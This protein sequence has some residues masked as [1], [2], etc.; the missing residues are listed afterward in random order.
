MLPCF[1]RILIISE[2]NTQLKNEL[3]AYINFIYLLGISRRIFY[4]PPKFADLK[5]CASYKHIHT[6]SLPTLQ[7]WCTVF[8]VC[9]SIFVQIHVLNGLEGGK[10]HRS[11][12]H[13]IF[14]SRGKWI[15]T[16]SACVELKYDRSFCCWRDQTAN[17]P[18]K[19]P[20]F[21]FFLVTK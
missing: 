6:S 14:A 15:L 11:R 7:I 12:S 1:L 3:F 5:L 16:A 20:S 9:I 10:K 19:F 18:T 8:I 2:E 17:V 4:P 13:A 21:D